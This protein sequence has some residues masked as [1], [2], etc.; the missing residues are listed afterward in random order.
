VLGGRPVLFLL[1][2]SAFLLI[3]GLTATGQALL[4]TADSSAAPVNGLVGSD[5][6]TVRSFVT[7]NLEPGDLTG[8]RMSAARQR[9]IAVAGRDD[10][11]VA[12]RK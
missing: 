11:S 3:V 5:A 8:G 4:V 2:F 10:P 1:V 6:A 12:L 7:L 9:G